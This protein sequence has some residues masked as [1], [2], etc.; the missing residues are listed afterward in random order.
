MKRKLFNIAIIGA[1]LIALCFPLYSD[2]LPKPTWK[3]EPEGKHE[4]LTM[5]TGG[6]DYTAFEEAL[7]EAYPEVELDIVTYKGTDPATY[8]AELLKSGQAPDIFTSVY[9]LDKDLQKKNL[10]DLSR[11]EFVK[12]YSFSM[13]DEMGI[14]KDM[15]LIPANV[16]LSGIYYNKTLMEEHGWQVPESF[17]E[18]KALVKE[19]RA[20]GLKVALIETE[21]PENVFP[22]FMNVAKTMFLHTPEGVQWEKDFLAG[23]A[24][25]EGYWE[26]IMAYVQQWIECGLLDV[27]AGGPEEPNSR[28]CPD[29]DKRKAFA[30]GATVFYF[31]A[32]EEDERFIVNNKGTDYEYGI[33]P[34]ISM[35]GDTNLYISCVSRYYGINKALENDPNPQKL[36][37]A[38]KVLSFIGTP[39]GQRALA[40][41]NEVALMSALKDG[42]LAENHPYY[43]G[44]E[45]FL[46]GYTVP[47]TYS[48][49]E[50]SMKLLGEKFL[51]MME[52]KATGDDVIA[53]M[54]KVQK[55]SIK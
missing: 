32:D 54:D 12:N 15:Y 44:E 35:D 45:M 2:L 7:K 50:H 9:L 48:G 24:T 33:M 10:V 16:H 18:M 55:E 42:K 49:W 47:S 30:N 27:K 40:Q 46:N 52:G 37:D 21:N 31:A 8:F 28:Y 14:E 11:Y 20:A 19:I 17:Q 43:K 51:D 22:Y 1:I 29:T 34:W 38:Q 5:I 41:G 23:E 3:Q 36:K 25:A 26:E 13:L 39:E 6:M 4:P 53:Y